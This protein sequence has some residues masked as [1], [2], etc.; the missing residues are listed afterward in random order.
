MCAG[1][2]NVAVEC[3]AHNAASARCVAAGAVGCRAVHAPI[4]RL[5]HIVAA[6]WQFVDVVVGLEPVDL[7]VD[8]P[9]LD[10]NVDQVGEQEKQR[11]AGAQDLLRRQLLSQ[12]AAP[13][14]PV[15]NQG[16]D[17]DNCCTDSS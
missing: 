2:V 13:T 3:V 10:S 8:G 14:R 1:C 12:L 16:L 4:Q 7:L 6:D 5:Q 9:V 17:L 11:L 15:I